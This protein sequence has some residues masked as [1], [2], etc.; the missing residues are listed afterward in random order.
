MSTQPQTDGREFDKSKIIGGELVIAGGATPA[1]P[2][3]VEE[4]LD[5][6][7]RPV[8]VRAEADRLLAIPFRRDVCPRAFPAGD[9][10]DPLSVITAICEQRRSRLPFRQRHRAEA[11]PVPV[12]AHDRRVDHL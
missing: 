5:Q 7:S 8:K 9:I 6:V 1:L 2:D 11:S 3:L 4:P 10:S 12:H